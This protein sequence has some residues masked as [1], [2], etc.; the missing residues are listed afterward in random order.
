MEFFNCVIY[1]S[2]TSFL[3]FVVGR[4][5]ARYPFNSDAFPYRAF[6]FEKDGLIY[7]KFKIKSWQSKVPDMSRIVPSLVPSKSM[8]GPLDAKKLEIMLRETCVA[9]LTH[10]LL[11]L[12]G[13]YGCYHFLHGNTATFVYLLYLLLNVPC[14]MIQRYNRPRLKR[15]LAGFTRHDELLHAA[16]QN[17]IPLYSSAND[18]D[19]SN[20]D[21]ET[22]RRSI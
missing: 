3:G 22:S 10:Y 15:V 16:R 14:M 5:L 8:D 4:F 18:S 6:K 17:V 7:E 2:L 20:S 9:E 13:M 21:M 19:F 11:C 1:L 12:S